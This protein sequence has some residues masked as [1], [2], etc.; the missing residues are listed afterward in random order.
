[1]ARLVE[2]I[3]D[4]AMSSYRTVVDASL[5]EIVGNVPPGITDNASRRCEKNIS[6][7]VLETKAYQLG[8]QL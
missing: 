8:S 5:H 4:V 2:W 6:K 7:T 1:V 3:K